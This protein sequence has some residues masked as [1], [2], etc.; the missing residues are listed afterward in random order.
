MTSASQFAGKFL[1][2]QF[3]AVAPRIFVQIP[4]KQDF[5]TQHEFQSGE[6]LTKLK[7]LSYSWNLLSLEQKGFPK[8][9]IMLGPSMAAKG[10]PSGIYFKAI[11]RCLFKGKVQSFFWRRDA[12]TCHDLGRFKCPE[13]VFM[14]VGLGE[15]SHK[16]ADIVVIPMLMK[17]GFCRL[18]HSL[19]LRCGV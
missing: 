15:L 14:E 11:A 17:K 19:E 4:R 12:K 16:P 3:L 1:A 7:S 9:A 18:D 2:Q 13:E 10:Q 8:F 5:W 6:V